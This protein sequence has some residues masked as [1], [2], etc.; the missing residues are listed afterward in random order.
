[1]VCLQWHCVKTRRNMNE[2]PLCLHSLPPASHYVCTLWLNKCFVSDCCFL[3][4]I[5]GFCAGHR[6]IRK[7]DFNCFG[8]KL[9][10]TQSFTRQGLVRSKRSSTAFTLR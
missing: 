5:W 7:C 8:K 10:A 1:M 2:L 3:T 4:E 9:E 6:S